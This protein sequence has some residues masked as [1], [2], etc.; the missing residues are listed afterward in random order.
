[1]RISRALEQAF[2]LAV[3][4]ARRRRHEFLSIEHIFFALLHDPQIAAILKHCGGDVAMLKRDMEHYLDVKVERLP[5]GV[6]KTLQQTLGFQRV[7]QRAAAHVQ[8]AGK[9]EIDVENIFVAL[10]R[11]P[12]SHAAFLLA[13]Q[14]VSRLD[15]V[16][17]LSHGISKIGLPNDAREPAGESEETEADEA[18]APRPNKKPLQAFTV[19]LVEQAAQGKI[20]PLIGREKEIE[21][22]IRVLCRRRK[23]NPVFVGDAGVGKTALA[24]GFALKVHR[25]EVP[26]KLKGLNVYALDM[27][28]LLA[29]TRFRGDFEQRLKDVLGALKKE[30]GAILF[31]DEIHTV[32]GA[33]ATSG[34]SLDASN[35]LKPALASGELRDRKSVV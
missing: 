22:T 10:F 31:I 26:D 16:S 13:Q 34:G 18:G 24:E 12:E 9:E 3:N 33:G 5:E 2:S 20:D 15:V 17:Y 29:G 30:P 4:E 14:G 7:V 19:N 11:E 25:G 6:E 21:R 27:G 28:A 1:M 35:I 23:N 32:V 8:S